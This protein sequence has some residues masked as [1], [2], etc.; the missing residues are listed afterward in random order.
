MKIQL[1]SIA[2]FG[3]LFFNTLSEKIVQP[4]SITTTEEQ[5]KPQ[6]VS[7]GSKITADKALTP[8]QAQAKYE[9]LKKGDTISLKFTSEI[10]SVCKKKGCW[11]NM[12]LANGKEVFVKF[13][14]YGFFVPLNADGSKAIVSGKA[15]IDVVSVPELR[16]YAQDAGKS[17][18]EI[19][20]IKEPKVTYAF[21][22]D[23]VL[24]QK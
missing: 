20:K 8:K 6:Y 24:I 11:M 10:K 12:P 13:K 7:F 5:Q 23:G 9:Q 19:E 15:F 22:A 21:L 4:T 2:L 18:E 3:A 16:H 14:D 17:K 1:L